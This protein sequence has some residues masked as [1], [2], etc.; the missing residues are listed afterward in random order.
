MR[1]YNILLKKVEKK[2]GHNHTTFLGELEDFCKKK[3]GSKFVGVFPADRI[4]KIKTGQYIICN[5]D[6]S[7]EPGSHW[8][9]AIKIPDGLIMYDSFGRKTN[10]ILPSILKS[11]NGQI[12]DTDYDAEQK[13][14]ETNCGQRCCSVIWFYDLYGEA[15]TLMI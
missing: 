2:I 6:N 10:K 11:G 14:E 15:E 5:L 3:F 13:T 9:S 7:N 8:V 4:P 1:K 12:K